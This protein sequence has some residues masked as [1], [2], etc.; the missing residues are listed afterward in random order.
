MSLSSGSSSGGDA[1]DFSLRSHRGL[2]DLS[3]AEVIDIERAQIGHDIHDLLL[4]LIFAASANLQSV[5]R[6]ADAS[7]EPKPDAA[8]IVPGSLLDRIAA[9]DHWLR[10][11]LE[12]GRTLLTQIYPPELDQ[13]TWLAAAKDTARRICGDDCE[14]IWHADPQS[15]VCDPKWNRDLA[16]TAYRVMIES[17]RNA[18]RHG[19]AETV[20]IRCEPDQLLIVDDGCGFDPSDV[21]PNRFGIRAMKS[22][23]CLVGKSLAVESQIGGPTTVRLQL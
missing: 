10:Q 22:R 2:V 16:T 20:S 14:V 8:D 13:T 5:L 3:A 15:P 9:S 4:P 23:A 7:S 17:L 1:N 11:A 12:V 19:K 6:S 18:I 21:D